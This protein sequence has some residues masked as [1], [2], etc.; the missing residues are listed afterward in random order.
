MPRLQAIIEHQFKIPTTFVPPKG[1]F[2]FCYHCNND[3][4]KSVANL[5]WGSYTSHLGNHSK[6][7]GNYHNPI[8]VFW[9]GMYKKYLLNPIASEKTDEW[10]KKARE[11]KKEEMEKK[12]RT[13]AYYVEYR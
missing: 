10:T 9:E 12:K 13:A 6:E 2:Y 7:V 11:K 3:W 1:P 4:T 5:G 8:G